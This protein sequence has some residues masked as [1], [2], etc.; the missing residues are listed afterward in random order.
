M[1]HFVGE[2][3]DIFS[4][5]LFMI[6]FFAGVLLGIVYALRGFGVAAYTHAIYNLSVLTILTTNGTSG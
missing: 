2:F 1:F 4:L 3:G 6:R 5:N